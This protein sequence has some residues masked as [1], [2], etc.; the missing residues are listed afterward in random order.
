M[1]GP[2][3]DQGEFTALCDPRARFSEPAAQLAGDLAGKM[4]VETLLADA[5][6][7]EFTCAGEIDGEKAVDREAGWLCG[8]EIGGAAI[9]KDREGE[10]LLQF[11]GLL[12]VQ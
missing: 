11:L 2:E 12:H 4:H 10:Q 6:G 3:I 8:H 1:N 7:D 9:G 5:P